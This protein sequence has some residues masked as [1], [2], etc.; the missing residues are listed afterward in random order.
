MSLNQLKFILLFLSTGCLMAALR[1]ISPLTSGLE[2]SSPQLCAA[3]ATVAA[4]S[5]FSPPVLATGLG[6][7]LKVDGADAEGGGCGG[8]SLVGVAAA[9]S[10]FESKP[11]SGLSLPLSRLALRLVAVAGGWGTINV[12][13]TGFS[14]AA[15]RRC[16]SSS[17]NSSFSCSSFIFFSSIIHMAKWCSSV[18]PFAASSFGSSTAAAAPSTPPPPSKLKFLGRYSAVPLDFRRVMSVA[19]KIPRDKLNCTLRF[20]NC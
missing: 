8:G 2:L 7:K 16:L 9:P 14:V 20:G 13:A 11:E 15:R 4:A 17:S 10:S 1:D 18:A 12:D 5:S 3:G 19:S 6:A